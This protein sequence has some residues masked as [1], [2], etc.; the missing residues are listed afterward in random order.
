MNLCDSMQPLTGIMATTAIYAGLGGVYKGVE[1][2][3]ENIREK[4]DIWNRVIGAVCA[5]SLV[6]LRTGSYYTS[7]GAMGALGCMALV[8]GLFD[9]IGPHDDHVVAHRKAMYQE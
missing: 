5:G 9:H 3:S 6:G 2:L 4:E 8:S 1:K 7:G